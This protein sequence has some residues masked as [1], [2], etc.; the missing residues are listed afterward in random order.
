MK[1]K[2]WLGIGLLVLGAFYVFTQP[3]SAARSIENLGGHAQD[4]GAS[5][6]QF[7]ARLTD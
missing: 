1:I 2:K 4:A 7:M 5:F 3:D 6:G